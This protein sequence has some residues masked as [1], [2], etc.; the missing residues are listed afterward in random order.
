MPEPTA[1]DTLR[2]AAANAISLW[3]VAAIYAHLKRCVTDPKNNSLV[4]WTIEAAWPPESDTRD[5]KPRVGRVYCG[6]YFEGC[7]Y[8]FRQEFARRVLMTLML[9]GVENVRWVTAY[10]DLPDEDSPGIEYKGSNGET[11]VKAPCYA[12]RLW[13]FGEHDYVCDVDETIA[14]FSMNDCGSAYYFTDE[15]GPI[16]LVI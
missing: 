8:T 7:W 14:D 3:P 10:D 6:L 5:L 15:S 16:T 12:G 11:L 2:R 9:S 13:A 1:E 4:L